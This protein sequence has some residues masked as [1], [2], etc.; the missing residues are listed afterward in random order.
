MEAAGAVDAKNAPTAPCKTR[1]RVSHSY[2]R[3]S[4]RGPKVNKCHPCSRLTLLPM[5]PVAPSRKNFGREKKKGPRGG[6]GSR[7]RFQRGKK[8][9]PPG[10]QRAAIV[11]AGGGGAGGGEAAK[12]R[13]HTR[14]T[15]NMF[16]PPPAVRR[17]KWGGGGGER[18]FWGA[19]CT[20]SGSIQRW[21]AKSG[22]PALVW[23]FHRT[24]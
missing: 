20:L 13:M 15:I 8:F 9:R 23:L 10:E 2:H 11:G 4:S 16:S 1:R 5:F 3:P 18:L 7:T 24:N 21:A 17:Q 6:G 14:V 19:T 22:K 12:K